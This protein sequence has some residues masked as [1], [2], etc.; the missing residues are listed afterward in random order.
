MDAEL[1][2]LEQKLSQLLE[3]CQRLRDENH[4]LRQQ[5]AYEQNHNKHLSDKLAGARTRL[6]N[7]LERIPEA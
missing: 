7:L 3:F 4:R 6:A 5:L 2:Q 1:K